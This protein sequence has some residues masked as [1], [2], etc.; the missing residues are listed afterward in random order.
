MVKFRKSFRN[1]HAGEIAGFSKQH[2][3]WLIEKNIADKH[4]LPK[5]EEKKDGEE[6]RAGE[7]TA[8]PKAGKSGKGS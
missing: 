6:Q 5:V 1:Y 2:E 3:A 8:G 7:G 4:E